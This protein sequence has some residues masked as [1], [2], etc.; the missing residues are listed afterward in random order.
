V[1][2]DSAHLKSSKLV[3]ADTGFDL[4]ATRI[5]HPYEYWHQSR[6][7][8]ADD[9]AY[10]SLGPDSD[11]SMRED[12]TGGSVCSS[13]SLWYSAMRQFTASTL[14]L[15]A[16]FRKWVVCLARIFIPVAKVVR[17]FVNQSASD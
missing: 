7:D 11:S 15:C 1:R 10:I 14:A 3:D 5:L 9:R 12:R 6:Q 13:D 16:L 4:A 17:F 2:S 8:G